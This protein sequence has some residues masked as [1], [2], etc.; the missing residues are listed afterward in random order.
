LQNS[1]KFFLFLGKPFHINPDPGLPYPATARNIRMM[2]GNPS[3]VFLVAICRVSPEFSRH[4]VPGVCTAP[5]H[6]R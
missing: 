6:R 3:P 4:E 2:N 5:A 1:I